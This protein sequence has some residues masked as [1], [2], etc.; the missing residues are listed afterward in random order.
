MSSVP[1]YSLEDKSDTKIVSVHHDSFTVPWATAES[2]VK[3]HFLCACV[4][5]CVFGDDFGGPHLGGACVIIIAKLDT[6]PCCC[7][8][9]LVVAAAAVA[10]TTTTT[11]SL[12]TMTTAES[13]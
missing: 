6:S 9:V 8:W 5:V 13:C 1:W 11:I 12:V 2:P 4:C 7:Y 10:A 3:V